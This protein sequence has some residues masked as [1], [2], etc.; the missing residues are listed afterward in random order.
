M[1]LDRWNPS[2]RPDHQTIGSTRKCCRS[3]VGSI[4]GATGWSPKNF[5]NVFGLTFGSTQRLHRRPWLGFSNLG[6]I[7]LGRREPAL[8]RAV[9]QQPPPVLRLWR[10]GHAIGNLAWAVALCVRMHPHRPH[11]RGAQGR[12]LVADWLRERF[13]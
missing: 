10:G 4:W 5:H 6:R 13:P 7:D 1:K 8:C 11:P 3:G 2:H 9:R 12:G